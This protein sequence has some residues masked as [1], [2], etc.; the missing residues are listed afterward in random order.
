[1]TTDVKD[2]LIC[3]IA[4]MYYFQD[5]TQAEI[6]KRLFISRSNVSRLLK[7]ARN[8][9]LVE[10]KIHYSS[11]RC[12]YLEEMIGSQFGLKEV[13]I[14]DH[15]DA[16]QE[17]VFNSLCS[18]IAN[19]LHS[20]IK[21]WSVVGVSRGTVMEGVLNNMTYCEPS[22]DNLKLVQMHGCESTSESSRSSED[23]MRRMLRLCGG[24][25][26]YLNAPLYLNSADL[27]AQLEQEPSIQK[28]LQLISQVELVITGIGA[29]TDNWRKTSFLAKYLDETTIL[30]LIAMNSVGHIFGQFFDAYGRRINHSI[31]YRCLGVH[32]DDICKIPHV[33]AAAY[34]EDRGIST[35]GALRGG[36]ISVLF[37]DRACAEKI[38]ELN[39]DA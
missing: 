26:Y 18:H 15:G 1:M 4:N 8:R 12:Y 14:Y 7:S 13:Y 35:L 16:N 20:N 27:R 6:A 29:L 37:A 2:N 19:Y 36:L 38:L 10:I 24:T 28:T 32:F 23:L 5:M 11:E 39:K 21:E 17:Q 30:E 31:N 3:E 25:A 33:V 9:G 34:G 22:R